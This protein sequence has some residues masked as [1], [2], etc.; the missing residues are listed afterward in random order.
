MKDVKLAIIYYSS[1]G[2]NYKLSKAAEEAA[3]ELDVKEVKLLRIAETVPEEIM[4]RNEDWIKNFKAT[5]DI[6]VASADDLEWADAVIFSAPTRFGNLPSQFSSFIDTTG[7]LWQKGKL[8]NKVISAMTSAGN[9][10]GG[11]EAT[12][13]S[14]YKSMMHWGAIIANPGYSDPVIFET[15]GNPYGFSTVGGSDLSEK[16]KEAIKVQVKRA[17]DIAA[18]IKA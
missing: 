8:V 6:P 7:P 9:P 2:T 13:L 17:V 4:E 10:H 18:K 16:D 5:K 1:T 11:Q 12:L 14:L 15:G 3:K